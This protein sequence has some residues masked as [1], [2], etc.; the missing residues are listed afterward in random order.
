M[1]RL[2]P[3]LPVPSSTGRALAAALS[4][5]IA[6]VLCAAIGANVEA[7]VARLAPSTCVSFGCYCEAD[8]AHGPREVVDAWSS[9]AP[10]VAGAAL[11][12]SA[13][14]AR[15]SAGTALTRSRIP[16]LLLSGAASSIAVFS[17]QY[18]ATHTL[19]GEWLDATSLYLLAGFTIAWRIARLRA[20]P[21]RGFVL[22]YG[23]IVATPAA[24]AWAFPAT[25]KV[26]FVA[27]ATAAIV[28][29][30]VARRRGAATG[31]GG[32]LGFAVGSFVLASVAWTL[33]WTR[34]VCDP[35]SVFQLHAA[36]H[37]LSAPTI[38]ALHAYLASEADGDRAIVEDAA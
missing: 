36:W 18:H 2:I 20:L 33:D 37:V 29:E 14:G 25:R 15:R 28:I 9:L 26:A 38:L 8:A 7:Q 22:V 32:L 34:R 27:L 31:R 12:W 24:L 5:A 1:L 35:T 19:L 21:V 4:L 17:F 16:T 23:G 3:G 10:A 13:L 30:V 11:L 6:I